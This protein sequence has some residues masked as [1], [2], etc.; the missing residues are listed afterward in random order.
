[1]KI[2]GSSTPQSFLAS[3]R[4]F[5]K[6]FRQFG[7]LQP[8]DRVLDVGC[9]CGRVAIPLT[10]YLT[11]GSYTGFDV[12]PDLVAWCRDHIAPGRP[13]FRFDL[14]DVANAFYHGHGATPAARFRFPYDDGAFDFTVLTS[15]FTHMLEDDFTRYAREVARTLTPGGTAFMTFFLMNEEALRLK[16]TPAAKLSFR[17][18]RGRCRVQDRADPEGAVAY[19]ER[20]ARAILR[21]AGLQVQQILLGSWCGRSGT[22]S[23]QDIVIARRSAGS[24]EGPPAAERLKRWLARLAR[25]A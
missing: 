19:P 18:R 17:H 5:L 24:L 14:A 9:G 12:V 4:Q 20:L 16:R 11:T 1:V 15:V 13:H 3:G 2:I 22:V 8:G 25:R 7:R 6:I 21:A 10:G 23:F